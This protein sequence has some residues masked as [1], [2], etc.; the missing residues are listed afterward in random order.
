VE[1]RAGATKE[2]HPLAAKEGRGA[3]RMLKRE[4]KKSPPRKVVKGGLTLAEEWLQRV[5]ESQE[6]GSLRLWERGEKNL[7]LRGVLRHLLL[8]TWADSQG[9]G[10]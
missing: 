4:G 5:P 9:Q 2:I 7:A 10:G 6:E 3:R 8:R 1:A